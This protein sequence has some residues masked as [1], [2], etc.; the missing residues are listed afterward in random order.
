MIKLTFMLRLIE[1]GFLKFEQEAQLFPTNFYIG[2]TFYF[3][4]RTRTV[5]PLDTVIE[6]RNFTVK[7]TNS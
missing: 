5:N 6:L 3:I 1:F 4:F 2:M 7:R